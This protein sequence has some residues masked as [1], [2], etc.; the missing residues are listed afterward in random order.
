[1]TLNDI[2]KMG[3][4]LAKDNAPT[5]LTAVGAV[6]TLAT[7][8]LTAKATF[9]AAKMISDKQFQLNVH[10]K[11]HEL[12]NPEKAAL[13][14]KVYILPAGAAAFTITCVVSANRISTKRAAAV[15]A[16]YA[17][18]Q[19]KFADYKD[20]VLEKLGEKKEQA[21][22][23]DIAQDQMNNNPP[24][25]QMLLIGDGEV[26]CLDQ[27]T[28]RYFH[29]TVEK[30]KRAENEVNYEIM[31]SGYAVLSDFY[32]RIGLK[33]TSFSEEFG[34]RMPAKLDLLW[35]TVLTP[36]GKPCIAFDIDV[37]AVRGQKGFDAME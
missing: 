24:S 31:N 30:I 26:L 6:G 27:L 13:V 9:K 10:E 4:K 3:E 16:A 25:E 7:G 18:S 15:A 32:E 2:L 17:I 23:D 14:W 33:A 29:S 21:I 11:S 20:K 36:D 28:G 19:D 1:M 5:I 37:K 22:R 34:W 12:T 8:Y 35:S